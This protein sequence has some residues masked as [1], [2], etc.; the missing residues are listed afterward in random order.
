MAT[1]NLTMFRKLYKWNSRAVENYL[2]Q[3]KQTEIRDLFWNQIQIKKYHKMTIDDL[4][5]CKQIFNF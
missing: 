1:I 4:Q 2:K 3:N 5:N